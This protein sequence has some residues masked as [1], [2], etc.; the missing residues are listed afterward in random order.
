MIEKKNRGLTIVLTDRVGVESYIRAEQKCLN[1]K[2]GISICPVTVQVAILDLSRESKIIV[3]ASSI[4]E[5]L[6]KILFA[7]D[8]LQEAE[9]SFLLTRISDV[10]V[11]V[12][13]EWDDTKYKTGDHMYDSFLNLIAEGKIYR[14]SAHMGFVEKVRKVHPELGGE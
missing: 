11:S 13:N 14:I 3:S 1:E 12:E 5:A 2:G 7:A 6:E 10:L 4:S 9:K 8:G